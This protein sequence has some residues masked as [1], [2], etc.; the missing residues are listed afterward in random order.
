M[1]NGYS[2]WENVPPKLQHLPPHL[3]T[4][5][6]YL[7]GQRQTGRLQHETVCVAAGASAC[8]SWYTLQAGARDHL[9]PSIF[10][11]YK[12]ASW[13]GLRQRAV[14][15]RTGPPSP[16]AA[17]P[18]RRSGN[19]KG[20]DHA[21]LACG[22][23]RPSWHLRSYSRTSAQPRAPRH[24]CLLADSVKLP[25]ERAHG[26]DRTAGRSSTRARSATCTDPRRWHQ[27]SMPA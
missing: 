7:R 6:Q 8:V 12:P 17:T 11:A 19:R 16:C 21:E 22:S 4:V 27:S 20:G 13:R 15:D 14:V 5:N 18:Q 10:D 2:P 26:S 3:L 1:D 25:C 24:L 9:S 23:Q